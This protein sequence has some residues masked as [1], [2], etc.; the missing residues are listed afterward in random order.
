MRRCAYLSRLGRPYGPPRPKCAPIGFRSVDDIV[1]S[2]NA[3]VLLRVP[4][5]RF[6]VGH[7]FRD[8]LSRC[9]P[10]PPDLPGSDT[11]LLGEMPKVG[12][13]ES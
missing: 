8:G 7:V 5:P 1:L 6:R 3:F 13:A 2:I 11:A 12:G 9:N 10:V 4:T